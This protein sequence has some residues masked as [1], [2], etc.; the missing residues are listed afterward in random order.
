MSVVYASAWLKDRVKL[1]ITSNTSQ[2]AAILSAARNDDQIEIL[3]R[4]IDRQGKS[5]FGKTF[6]LRFDRKINA[7]DFRK[8]VFISIPR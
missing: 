2:I 1:T 5:L 8:R 3:V 7:L 4:E 6:W